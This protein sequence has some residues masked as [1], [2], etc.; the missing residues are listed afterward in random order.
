MR[1]KQIL[2]L[3]QSPFPP[4]I[5][6]EK[7]IRSLYENGFK[8]TI[9]CNQYEKDKNPDFE[10]CNI[11]RIKALFKN[12]RLNKITNFPIF[13]NPRFLVKAIEILVKMK[14][15]FIHAHDLPMVP[16]GMI[17]KQILNVPL[18]YDMHED[19]PEALIYFQKKGILNYIFKNPKIA[20]KLDNYCMK[21]SD[22]LIVVVNEHK[23]KLISRGVDPQKICII[24]NTVDLE[25]FG[26][27]K[28]DHSL[29][30][31]Y[32]DRYIIIYSGKVGP[33]RGLDVPILGLRYIINRIPNVLL[34]II[35][36]GDYI[37]ILKK[38]VSQNCLTNYVYFLPWQGHDKINSFL[39]YAQICIIPQPG[40]DFI[41]SGIPNKL[42]EYMS[43]GRTVLTS[44]AK[45]MKRVIETTG[46][47]LIFKSNNPQDFAI[48]F[49]YKFWF[50]W[51]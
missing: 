44:D 4:D 21:F 45:P 34:L 47:G 22:K 43:L 40:N 30:Q 19:Y 1:E 37:S 42:F 39:Q 11:V 48:K 49:R 18:I 14:P 50:K 41:N 51:D 12:P 25:S 20:K 26:N 38:I 27:E 29:M 23:Q 5:R 17:L 28:V 7:E 15:S 9:I 3:L 8:I 6:I 35:G 32:K 13:F 33:E 36:D 24:S 31:P 10:F 2:M 46:A 16:L